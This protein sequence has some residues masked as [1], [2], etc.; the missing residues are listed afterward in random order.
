VL[1]TPL[2][3]ERLARAL[4]MAN[5]NDPDEPVETTAGDISPL[6]YH[7]EWWETPRILATAIAVYYAEDPS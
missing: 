3:V 6:D 1:A 4:L 7:A 5:G 2:D